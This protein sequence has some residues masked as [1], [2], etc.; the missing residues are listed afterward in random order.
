MESYGILNKFKNTQF[1]VDDSGHTL[2]TGMMQ[3]DAQISYCEVYGVHSIIDVEW[4][5][6]LLYWCE[7][8]IDTI[9]NNAGPQTSQ[10][11]DEW[12]SLL[13]RGGPQNSTGVNIH[14]GFTLDFW[15]ICPPHPEASL[16]RRTSPARQD[17]T[18]RSTTCLPCAAL[19]VPEGA[20][21][22]LG[23]SHWPN[24]SPLEFGRFHVSNLSVG[25]T[26]L[27]LFDSSLWT[28]TMFHLINL[29]NHI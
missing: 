25:R 1:V 10:T 15:R 28:I 4:K 12:I 9:W 5:V 16:P 7:N 24:M 23:S 20:R 2:A 19:A 26:T 14:P 11:L 3:H 29:V 21:M 27:W 8:Y 18:H 6:Y 17:F 13:K 22:S